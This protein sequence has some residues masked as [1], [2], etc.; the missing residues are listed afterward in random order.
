VAE[1]SAPKRADKYFCAEEFLRMSLM[2]KLTIIL[3]LTD[4]DDDEKFL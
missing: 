3:T 2:T 4:P 1:Y